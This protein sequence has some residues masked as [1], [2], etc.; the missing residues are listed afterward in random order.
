MIARVKLRTIAIALSLGYTVVRVT[1][2][3]ATL[4]SYGINPW[5]FFLIDAITG[6]LYVLG[7]EQLILAMDR[8]RK[9]S[10]SKIL[11]WS[12]IAIASFALPYL[13]LFTASRELPLGFT[14]GLGIIVLLFLVNALLSF[15]RRVYRRPR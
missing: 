4:A 12:I 8:R 13:Y 2:V 7:I 15:G 3:H 5:V 6:I 1:V 11:V 14:I 10:G 9:A